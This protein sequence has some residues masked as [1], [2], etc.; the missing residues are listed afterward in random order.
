MHI[1]LKF[2]GERQE[3]CVESLKRN[4]ARLKPFGG[5]ELRIE[6]SGG[7]PSIE[8]PRIVWAGISGEVEKLCRLQKNVDMASLHSGIDR[9]AR[10][11]SPHL[12]LGRRNSGAPLTDTALRG[13]RDFPI[14]TGTWRAKEIILMKSELLPKGPTYTPL[15][16]F[17][18]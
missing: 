7:F 3:E 15:E 5:C 17:K 1:T 4:L 13:I 2:C 12:T 6:G 10:P 14:V 9:E 11:F 18:I 8:R 16:L